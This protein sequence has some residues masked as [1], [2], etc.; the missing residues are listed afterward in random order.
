M[1]YIG[2]VLAILGIAAGIASMFLGAG[3]IG[4]VVMLLGFILMMLLD[5]ADAYLEAHK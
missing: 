1:Y 2:L 3:M 4:W 5:L